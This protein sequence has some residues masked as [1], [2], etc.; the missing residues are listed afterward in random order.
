MRVFYY[1][2]L[3]ARARGYSQRNPEVLMILYAL[4]MLFRS[5][6]RGS[7]PIDLSLLSCARLA[8]LCAILITPQVVAAHAESLDVSEIAP[9]VFVHQGRIEPMSGANRGDIAN[10]GFIVGE[11]CVAVID[12]GGSPQVGAALRNAVEVQ[13]KKPV[14]YVVNTHAHP[15]HVF[16]NRAFSD[17]RPTFIAHED[18]A[19]ALGTRM[20]TYLER[21]SELY[22]RPLS[23]KVIMPPEQTVA[24]TATVNLG[25]RVLKLTAL[26]TGHTNTDLTV[27]DVQTR[28]LWAGDSLFVRHIPVLDGSIKGWLKVMARLRKVE[29]ER[30]IPGHGPASVPWPGALQPQRRYLDTIVKDIRKV[31]DRGGTIEEAVDTVGY[32]ARKHWLLFDEYHRRNV[33]AA[34]VELEWE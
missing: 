1:S 10:I 21:F 22:G 17:R 32:E 15:D 25:N 5:S 31:I 14:C 7:L 9:G 3:G 8:V 29:A 23:P 6:I 24:H 20:L 4:K 16:G 27:L 34:F 28:T 12:T 11:R 18:Y 33:T 26:P 13:T 2:A 30:A 19:E